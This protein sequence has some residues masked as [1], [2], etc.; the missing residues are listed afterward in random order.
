[1]TDNRPRWPAARPHDPVGA[2]NS[3]RTAADRRAH[4]ARL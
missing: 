2:G 4:S 3:T 1:M